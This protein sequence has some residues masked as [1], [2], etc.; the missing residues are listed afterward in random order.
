MIRTS[1]RSCQSG[2]TFQGDAKAFFAACAKT[3]QGPCILLSGGSS[4]QATRVRLAQSAIRLD[5]RPSPW[6]QV[7]LILDLDKAR[8]L[9]ST[10]VEVSFT[11]PSS[12][13]PERGY[14][15]F[16]SLADY[17]D[18]DAFPNLAMVSLREKSASDLADRVRKSALRAHPGRA[19]RPTSAL[20]AAWSAHLF[21][22]SRRPN[23]LL[24][25]I[26]HPG[27]A[28]LDFVF[29]ASG[30]DLTPAAATPAVSPEHLWASMRYFDHPTVEYV[31]TTRRRQNDLATAAPFV[32]PTADYAAF[33]ARKP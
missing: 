27:A 25:Q 15:S 7:S 19:E 30:I 6:S 13:G 20:L 18:D 12:T 16:F 10:G 11:P 17:A 26:A 5:E 23:P 33:R 24:E 1:N 3:H 4:L 32:D 28:F 31:F 14:V 22:P 29:A 8:V 9:A 2:Q 21:D